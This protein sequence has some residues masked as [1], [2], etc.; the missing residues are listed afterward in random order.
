MVLT[1]QLSGKE[2]IHSMDRTTIMSTD[3]AKLSLKTQNKTKLPLSLPGLHHASF[4]PDSRPS[5]G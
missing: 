4:I 3:Y 2:D 1:S 5:R